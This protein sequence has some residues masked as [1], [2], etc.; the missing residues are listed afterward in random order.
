MRVKTFDIWG[1][2]GFGIGLEMLCLRQAAAQAGQA[3]STA[4]GVGA[5]LGQ[6]A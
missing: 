1:E 3:A 4:A 6:E 5:G 2:D